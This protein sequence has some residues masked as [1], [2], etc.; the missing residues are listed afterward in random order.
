MYEAFYLIGGL[1]DPVFYLIGLI[2]LLV[3]VGF[4]IGF[5]KDWTY[6]LVLVMHGISTV[7]SYKQYMAPFQEVNLLFFAALPMLSACFVL[8]YLRDQDSMCTVDR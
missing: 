5:M 8:Y 1:P 4:L 7:S 6:L 3:L 2:E